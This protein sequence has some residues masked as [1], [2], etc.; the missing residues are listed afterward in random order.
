M[1]KRILTMALAGTLLAGA[2]QAAP[3]QNGGFETGPDT[4]AGFVTLPAGDTSVTGWIVTGAGIDYMGSEWQRAEGNHSLDLSSTAAGGIEQTFDTIAGHTYRVTF[5][6]AGNPDVP[7]VKE[8]TVS[9]TGGAPQNYQF[10]VS[11]RSL[12]DMG[13]ANQTYEFTASA[14]ATTLSFTSLIDGTAGPAL[15]NVVVTDLTPA[16]SVAA[17]PTLSQWA[18]MLM[19][20]LMAAL[21]LRGRGWRG[22]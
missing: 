6:L 1:N 19:A 17:V 9:A 20:G 14:A 2:A 12:A 22:R 16:A 18:L 7:V 21:A 10:D 8:V 11:G 5:A 3:F 4:S 13:W 15:D